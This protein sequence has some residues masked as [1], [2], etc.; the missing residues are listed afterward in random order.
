MK[1]HT[2]LITGSSTGIGKATAIEFARRGWNVAASMRSP[3][4]STLATD[5]GELFTPCLDVTDPASIRETISATL[6]RFGAIDALVNN[7]GFMLMGPLEAWR[8]GQLEAQFNTN[9]F[10]LVNVTRAVL[11]AMRRAGGGTIVNISSIGGRIGFPLG[12]AYHATK[13]AVEGLS[14]SLRYE[15]APLN[16]RVKVVEPGGIRTDF[17]KRGLQWVELPDYARTAIPMK[18]LMGEVDRFA[19]GPEP[20][21]QTVVKA[22]LDRSSKLRYAAKPGPFLLLHRLLPDAA[23]RCMMS[24]ILG[25]YR[26]PEHVRPTAS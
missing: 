10:G 8:E 23:W 13:F 1:S 25:W 11:P 7:A 17:V 26:R 19:P 6:D 21:A 22:T 16:I 15:L 18:R 4:S 3:Q 2:V 12:S 9:L 20:V 14:E 24:G 5:H